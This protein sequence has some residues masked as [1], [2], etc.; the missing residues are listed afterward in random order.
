MAA[1]DLDALRARVAELEQQLAAERDLADRMGEEAEAAEAR[2][3]T[4]ADALEAYEHWA[5]TMPGE[6]VTSPSI[7]QGWW[8]RRP[9]R[10]A[11]AALAAHGQQGTA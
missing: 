3:Q 6:G 9:E 7:W 2:A 10:K 5:A 1:D 8:G 11:R 4:L